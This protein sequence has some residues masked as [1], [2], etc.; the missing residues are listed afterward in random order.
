MTTTRNNPDAHPKGDALKK[1]W[2]LCCKFRDI[3]TSWKEGAAGEKA[4]VGLRSERWLAEACGLWPGKGKTL[5]VVVSDGKFLEAFVVFKHDL[6]Y[7]WKGSLRLPVWKIDHRKQET[8]TGR[9]AGAIGL[10]RNEVKGQGRQIRSCLPLR[11]DE[12]H[13]VSLHAGLSLNVIA[14]VFFEHSF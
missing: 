9:Q 6:I 14:K 11:Y 3:L 5:D 13:P 1:E 12:R 4:K 2:A 10:V 8:E 7:I